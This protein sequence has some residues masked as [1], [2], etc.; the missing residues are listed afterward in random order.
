MKMKNIFKVS[1]LALFIGMASCDDATDIIQE[2][3]LSEENAFRTLNDLQT[4]LNGVYAAYGPDFGG[5]GDGDIIVFNDLFTDNFK[6]GR[7]SSGQ[8]NTE[9]NWIIQP[10]TNFPNTLW[11]NRYA[12]INFSNRVLNAWERIAPTLTTAADIR[13]ADIIKGQLLAIR[14]L[15]HFDLL[16]YFTVD[17]SDRGAPGVIIM[18]FVPEITDAL[19]RNTVGEVFD[20]VNTDLIQ[21]ADY[22]G[23]FA[24]SGTT[25][26]IFYINQNTVNAI[27]ARVAL[28]EGNYTLAETLADDLLDTYTIATNAQYLN[29]FLDDA[30]QVGSSTIAENIFTLARVQGDNGIVA[31]WYANNAASDGSPFY[32]MSNQLFNSFNGNDVRLQV[33]SIESN[34]SLIGKY[35]GGAASQQ[36]NHVKLIRASEMLLISAEVK[37]RDGR[38]A[39][40]ATLIDRLTDARI[41]AGA[42]PVF[43][44]TNEALT[45]ILLERRLEF[46]FEG[47]RYLDLKRLGAEIGIG[48]NR[49]A[50][51]AA[52]FTAETTLPATDYRF[53]M[54]IPRNEINANPGIVQNPNY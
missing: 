1:L 16:Q 7:S 46:C 37:A 15:C 53:T 32:E 18:D 25:D 26:D 51:D 50:A 20:F 34:T 11:S 48:I 19:P 45:K 28:F 9:Y 29:L 4:G 38:L 10:L 36:I 8:G 6:R 47:H 31:L 39:E 41:G 54:P 22:L 43:G 5:N 12:T 27:R 3:E 23:T 40:A 30:P 52:T 2:S 14:A 13:Q 33:N 44:S 17:Y 49:D 35:R 24:P 21:A 42:A